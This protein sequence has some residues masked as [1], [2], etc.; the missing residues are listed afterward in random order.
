MYFFYK[1]PASNQDAEKRHIAPASFFVVGTIALHLVSGF[2]EIFS[3]YNIAFTELSKFLPSSIA[4]VV[5]SGLALG[6]TVVIE[7][8]IFVFLSAITYA[9]TR[10][11]FKGEERSLY[12]L[13]SFAL[14]LF[15]F[16][17]LMGSFSGSDKIAEK[18]ATSNNVLPINTDSLSIIYNLQS[19]SIARLYAQQIAEAKEET[20]R[21]R[22][23][24]PTL[25]EPLKAPH[26]Q[27]VKRLKAIRKESNYQYIDV[28][29]NNALTKITEIDKALSTKLEGIDRTEREQLAAIEKERKADKA[30][31]LAS[32]TET[33]A[34]GKTHNK[35]RAATV[36]EKYEKANARLWWIVLFAFIGQIVLAWSTAKME[37]VCGIDKVPILSAT[38]GR[39]F[40]SEWIF[41]RRERKANKR[42]TKLDQYRAATSDYQQEKPKTNERRDYT[43]VIKQPVK[44]VQYIANDGEGS[45]DDGIIWM[46]RTG[47]THTHMEENDDDEIS[48]TIPIAANM[49]SNENGQN[50]SVI[51][52]NSPSKQN[53][54]VRGQ[55]YDCANEGCTNT[56]TARTYN[57]SFCC[58][59]CKYEHHARMHGQPFDKLKWK[60]RKK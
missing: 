44:K 12:I 37:K 22:K 43:P 23:A 30:R 19:D 40:W 29:I 5:G 21:Q 13:Y 45:T 20:N 35:E 55:S 11:H 33:I 42:F 38:H 48:A 60:T 9:L 39:S 57:H 14:L 58:D 26:L 49:D 7:L 46:D 3:F 24:A 18:V 54:K 59:G 16:A 8:G 32:K 25:S 50:I 31:L 2:T 17:G 41:A 53:H 34:A 56:F 27:N 6:I 28:K 10:D 15:G 36:T 47:A 51:T 52:D 4:A 1:S